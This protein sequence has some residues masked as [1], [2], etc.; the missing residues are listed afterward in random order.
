MEYVAFGG[1]KYSREL[2]KSVNVFVEI[3]RGDVVLLF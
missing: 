2:K 1:Q 3:L